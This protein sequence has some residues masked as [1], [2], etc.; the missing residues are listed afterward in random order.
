MPHDTSLIST[1]VVG[2]VL[3]FVLGAIATRFRQPP[4]VGYLLAGV[5]V[6]PHTPGFVADQALVEQLAKYNLSLK[7]LEEAVFQGPESYN[8]V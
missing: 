4:L 3:A 1:I 6:G 8:F 7:Y 2:L 5:L